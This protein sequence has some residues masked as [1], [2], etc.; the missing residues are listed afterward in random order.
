MLQE[1]DTFQE[2]SNVR[3]FEAQRYSLMPAFKILHCA[4]VGFGFGQR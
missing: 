2:N 3:R 4:L 1:Q